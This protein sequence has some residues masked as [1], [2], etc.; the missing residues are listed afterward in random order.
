MRSRRT[1]VLQVIVLLTGIIYIAMGLL[2]YINPLF[3]FSIFAESVAENWLDLVRENELIGP[4]YSSLRAF[5]ALVFAAG[6]T[7]VMPLFDPLK[8]RLLVYFYGVLFPAMSAAVL[9]YHNIYL[10]MKNNEAA[11]LS[12]GAMESGT[13]HIVVLV[14]AAVF[15]GIL[16]FNIAG[17]L[18]TKAEAKEGRE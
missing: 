3:I 14:M 8:Y 18:I 15:L 12:E 1:N 16:L 9:I 17:L 13:Q 4:L 5:A 2:F 6:I 10:I 7:N 11:S